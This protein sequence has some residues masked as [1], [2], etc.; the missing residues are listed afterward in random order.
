MAFLRPLPEY[1]IIL[2]GEQGVGK[3]TFFK[4]VRDHEFT[5]STLSTGCDSLTH[6]MRIGNT[7]VKVRITFLGSLQLTGEYFARRAYM[8][9]SVDMSC[10]L[11]GRGYVPCSDA[12]KHL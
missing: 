4:R 10:R 2:L 5:A 7:E 6:T 9:H 11:H 3:T 1:K 8:I 12:A